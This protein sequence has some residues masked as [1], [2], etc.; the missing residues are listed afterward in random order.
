MGT[1]LPVVAPRHR[2]VATEPFRLTGG[3]PWDPN[4]EQVPL[5]RFGSYRLM[6]ALA[7]I[8]LV[9]VSKSFSDGAYKH[10]ILRD[11]S[12]TFP[13][14]KIS[15]IV[16]RSGLGKSTILK[17]IFGVESVNSG[18]ILVDGTDVVSASP[19]VIRDL[20]RSTIGYVFQTFNLVNALTVEE[21]IL[22]PRFF[23]QHDP[24][25]MELDYLLKVLDLPK[26]ILKQNVST[27]SGG[28]KQRVAIARALINNPTVLLADEPTGNLDLNNE[29]RVIELFR[30]INDEMGIA[31]I[32]VTHSHAVAEGA[33]ML[34]SIIEGDIRQ[35]SL[36][37]FLV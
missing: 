2:P 17:L 31:I 5:P 32:S 29:R 26:P 12:V 7:M 19:S 13:Q 24:G 16:G 3:P 28:E 11:A 23:S 25:M 21:N 34:F 15:S 35:I 20:R 6:E 14:G 22:L 18:S 27:I 9:N 30:R 37:D 33:D 4:P 1:L 36:D 8:E 10:V